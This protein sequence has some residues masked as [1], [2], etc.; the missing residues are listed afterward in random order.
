MWWKLDSALAQLNWPRSTHLP[1]S[2]PNIS[3]VEVLFGP[4]TLTAN[5]VLRR[6]SEEQQHVGFWHVNRPNFTDM[7]PLCPSSKFSLSCSD[8]YLN[9]AI[10][11]SVHYLS[12]F[13]AAWW[14]P[15]RDRSHL[16]TQPLSASI[17]SSRWLTATTFGGWRAF[18]QSSLT[19]AWPNTVSLLHPSVWTFLLMS[20]VIHGFWLYHFYMS[21]LRVSITGN[22]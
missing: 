14:K 7:I 11:H 8:C 13:E 9:R 16:V 21:I 4:R 2:D 18:I 12:L 5:P 19:Q 20:H 15:D 22:G 10:C 6:H 17:S 3:V 1:W